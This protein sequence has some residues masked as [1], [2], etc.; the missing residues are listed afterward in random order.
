MTLVLGPVKTEKVVENKGKISPTHTR[1][2]EGRPSL[3]FQTFSIMHC[4]GRE[5]LEPKAVR[6]T[7]LEHGEAKERRQV[8]LGSSCAL[9]EGS[10]ASAWSFGA[11]AGG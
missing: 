10:C 9:A 1:Q 7:I 11:S 4:V 3:S 6:G 5:D 8:V 2:A